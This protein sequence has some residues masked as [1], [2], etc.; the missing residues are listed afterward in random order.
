[1]ALDLLSHILQHAFIPVAIAYRIAGKFALRITPLKILANFKF[2]DLTNN[3][4]R[5]PMTRYISDVMHG[6][7]GRPATPFA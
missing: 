6:S 2:G 3:C 1:M 7:A 5:K 4:E